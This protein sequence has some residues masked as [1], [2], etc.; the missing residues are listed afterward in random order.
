MNTGIQDAYNLAWKLALVTQG[1]ASDAL[2]DTYEAERRP[3]AADVDP[4]HRRG[5]RQSRPREPQGAARPARR[6]AAAGLLCRR[7][8]RSRRAGRGA[9][10]PATACRTCRA[11]AAAASASR[12]GCSSCCA[13]PAMCCSRR[14][15]DGDTWKAE[16]AANTLRTMFPDLVRV[17][18]IAPGDAVVEEPP[19]VELI[20]DAA[21]AFRTVFGE[22]GGLWLVRPGRLS[23]P[24]P[25]RLVG[26]R[27]GRVSARCGGAEGGVTL[28]FSILRGRLRR[29]LR[30]TSVIKRRHPEV[31]AQPSLEGCLPSRRPQNPPARSS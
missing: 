28:G 24:P 2:L 19:G 16:A 11:C 29:H 9:C 25:R 3:V 27:G 14:S 10:A 6:H 13:A 23:R 26:M 21:G 22:P 18:A 4:A 5:Q 31:P 17:I 1:R 12:C 30:M 15:T 8:A 7:P 20:H